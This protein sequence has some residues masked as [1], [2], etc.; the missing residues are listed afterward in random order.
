MHDLVIRNGSV[1][2]GTG[3]PARAPG[4]A[5][6]AVDGERITG[7]GQVV[8]KGR[9]EIDAHGLL[10]TP[11]FVD[12]H[13]HYDGQVTWD[14]EV[15]PTSWHGVTT[16]VMGNCGVGFAPARPGKRDWLIQ[17]M[18]G[19]E[20]IPGTALAEGMTWN[21]E[22]FPEYLD[23]LDRMRRVLDVSALVPHGAV[24][25][26]V[27]GDRGGAN[28]EAT[29][30]EI[31]RMADLVREAIE[32]GAAGFSTTRTI[33]HRAKDGELAAGTLASA[34]ELVGIGRALGEA[35]AGVFEL[36]SDMFDP[37]A[38][39]A[40]MATVARESGRPVTFNCLQDDIRPEHWRRLIELADE[41][42]ATG[43]RIVPQ[44]AGRPACLLLG[45]DSTAHPFLFHR[46]WQEIAGL[47]REE[48][49]ARLRTAEVR[50]AMLAEK[51]EL[52]GIAAFLTS[53]YHKLFPLGDPP[54]Y[55]P[56]PDESL[57][58]VAARQGTTPEAVAYDHLC[59]QDGRGLLYLPL[60]GYAHGDFGALREMLVHPGT[61]LGLGDGGAHCG[62]L[63]DASLPSYMLSHWARDRSRGERLGLE[64]AVHMQTRGTAALYGFDDRGVLAPGYLADINVID[65]DALAIEAP[66]MVYDL[67]AGGRRMI[68][69]ARGYA[70]TV[71]RGVVVREDDEAT[72]ERPGRLLRGPQP[73]P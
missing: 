45:W 55:E 26:Y 50:D 21:W 34:D 42:T 60:L 16:I 25:A 69:R 41:A 57:Q 51:P 30:D 59:G 70:A 17:L 23:E 18:E 1:V 37:E 32:A 20:D 63:C 36:A 27:M 56:S 2:D 61:V 3:G 38:E 54:E 35:G 6:I 11:G 13:T 43:A 64:Q 31:V 39:F 28:A 67:P 15:T 24:R 19:V 62:L 48:R 10:V 12:I 58:A 8:G 49:L 53:S 44:V 52:V 40:W 68:Q 33:L 47:P 4:T 9:R 71:K 46:T 22:T 66:E 7:V 14:P 29:P 72:G 65:L 73:R 5:D